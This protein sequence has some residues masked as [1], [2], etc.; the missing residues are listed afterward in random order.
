MFLVEKRKIGELN[1]EDFEKLVELGVGNGGVV[2]KVLYK[3]SG[4]I[5]V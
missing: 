2:I 3:L 5:M 1:V 4:L